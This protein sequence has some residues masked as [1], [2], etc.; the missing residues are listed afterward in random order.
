M[1]TPATAR[2][3]PSW[4]PGVVLYARHHTG[5]TVV[6][7]VANVRMA[8]VPS[9]V[10][11]LPASM[12]TICPAAAPARA[13]VKDQAS[14]GVE[15][16]CAPAPVGLQYLLTSAMAAPDPTRYQTLHSCNRA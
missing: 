2:L 3:L 4:S 1:S 16:S 8:V 6:P 9:Y 11:P 10:L 12:L 13:S 7:A 15:P 14:A 5:A